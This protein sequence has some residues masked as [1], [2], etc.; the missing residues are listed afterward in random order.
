MKQIKVLGTGCPKCNKL[1][2]QTKIAIEEI[3]LDC[4][5]HKVTDIMEITRYGIMLTPALVVD[6]VVMENYWERDKPIYPTGQI[7]LQSH[8]SPLYF[9][10]IFIRE[11]ERN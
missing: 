11:I 4:N 5:L 2:E 8:S 3:G 1:F 10:N 9:R 7:E 6:D